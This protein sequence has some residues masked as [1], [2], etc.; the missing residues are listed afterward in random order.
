MKFSD[1]PG[2]AQVWV[3]Q[4]NRILTD[5]EV[6]EIKQKGE[7]FAVQWAAHGANL[8]A[9]FDVFDN[10]FLVLAVDQSANKT[11]GCSLD[12]ATHFIQ[13]LEKT[14][15]IELLNRLN[16]AYRD[17][18]G[19]LKITSM[20]AFEAMINEGALDENTTVYNNLVKTKSEF[21]SGWKTPASQSWHARLFA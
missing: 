11:S 5:R 16:I 19:V 20:S 12:E 10:A 9:A 7:A 21:M 8:E 18:E 17:S 2:E 14:Y 4:S 3:Y 15:Q 13:E 6:A 1:L